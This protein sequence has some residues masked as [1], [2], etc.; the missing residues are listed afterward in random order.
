MIAGDLSPFGNHAWQSTLCAAAAWVLTLILKR[1]RPAV[2]YW[3]W[4]AASLKFLVPFSLL[5]SAGSALGWR[6]APAATLPQ[7]VLPAAIGRPFTPP[8]P[9]SPLAITVPAVTPLA[10]VLFCL[11]LC[12]FAVS[13]FVQLRQWRRMR[14]ALLQSSPLDLGIP[15]PAF[16]C[17]APL[18][19]GV[20]GI[21]HPVLILPEGITGHLT[22]DQLQSII[23]HELCH[24]QRRDNLTALIHMAA[25]AAFWFHPLVWWI[26]LRLVEERER[27]CDE[28]VLQ[29]HAEP[30]IYAEGIL[31]VCKFYLESP[32]PC[33][34]GITGAG[35]KKRIEAIMSHHPGDSLQL[36]KRLL[37]AAAAIATTAGPAALGFLDAPQ[38]RAQTQSTSRLEFDVASVKPF[39]PGSAPENRAITASHGSL[40][41]SQESLRECIAWAYGLNNAGEITAAPSLDLDYALY[42]ISAKS[43]E[44]TTLDQL[45]LM[46]Q[47]LLAQRFKLSLRRKTEQRPVY[48]LVVGKD[49]AKLREVQ[50]EPVKGLH[51]DTQGGF[52]TIQ[53]ISRIAQ[54]SEYIGMFLDNPVLDGTGLTGVYDILLRVDLDGQQKQLPQPGQVFNGFGMTPGV[55]TAV[56][57]LGLKLVSRK[58]PVDILIVDYVEKPSAN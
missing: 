20:F 56:E 49:G 38:V 54:F 33:V 34:S 11:W 26:G 27:A 32:L 47:T 55:F 2:R 9:V 50:S 23:A 4:L 28:A 30:N 58:G 53:A 25:E 35:L 15:I 12:G 8:A 48:L 42:D 1:N 52:I 44:S 57:Q 31:N 37:L 13:V 45:R 22:P 46:L 7:I 39:K 14:A 51:I 10:P 6:S 3:L 24:V 41:I 21:L 40:R 19:P 17:P 18:E 5:F 43:A 29:T 16:S 36:P